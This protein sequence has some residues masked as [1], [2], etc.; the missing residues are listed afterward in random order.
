MMADGTWDAYDFDEG[1]VNGFGRLT[2]D[3][4]KD[5]RFAKFTS[6]DPSKYDDPEYW[7]QRAMFE[8]YI[9]EFNKSGITDPNGNKLSMEPD[10]NGN[11]Y[12]P[13]PYVQREVDTFKNYADM[14]Y[15][16]YDDESKALINDTFLGAF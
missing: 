7:Q 11:Y 14:L 5:P 9:Q 1:A 10:E 8:Q 3:V 6:K 15:G 13:R 12:L 4:M 16:H 2:Y